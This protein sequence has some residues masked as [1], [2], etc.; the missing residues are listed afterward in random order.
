MG[1]TLALAREDALGSTVPC[2]S[3]Y[4]YH[5]NPQAH[6][7]LGS[8]SLVWHQ[9]PLEWKHTENRLGPAFFPTCCAAKRLKICSSL[10]VTITSRQ[11]HV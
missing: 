2:S 9:W 5:K 8:N 1:E 7:E 10:S 11:A 3:S 4:I 6:R